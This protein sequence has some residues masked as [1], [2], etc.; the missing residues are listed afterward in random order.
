[1]PSSKGSCQPRDRIW[2]SAIE[3]RSPSLQSDSL[4]SEPTGKPKNTG[5]GSL[6]LLQRIFPTQKSNWS[7]LHCR[8]ILYQLSY[9][10]S[11]R[12]GGGSQRLSCLQALIIC[13]KSVGKEA[14]CKAGDPGSIAESGRS[15]GEGIGYPLQSS[16]ASLVVQLVKNP[17]T[18]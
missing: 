18:L 2:V 1:M 4:L 7:L 16:W 15:S 10:G 17:P 13:L 6:S 5:V 3:P 8:Q 12:S 14:I 9:P 11:P